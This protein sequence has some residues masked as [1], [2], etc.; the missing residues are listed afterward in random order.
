[1][2][3]AARALYSGPQPVCARRLP[4]VPAAPVY[5]RKPRMA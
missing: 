3:A 5:P 2:P 1:L 4:P